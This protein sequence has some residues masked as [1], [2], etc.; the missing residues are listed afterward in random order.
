MPQTEVDVKKIYK[1]VEYGVER[2]RNFR[3]WFVLVRFVL[4]HD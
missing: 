1:A 4:G 3:M 2:L